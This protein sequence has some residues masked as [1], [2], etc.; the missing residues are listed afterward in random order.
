MF[1]NS[2]TLEGL[3]KTETNSGIAVAEVDLIDKSISPVIIVLSGFI[4]IKVA[5]F[6]LA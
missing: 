4:Y 1:T 3:L 6:C 2:Y 5:L